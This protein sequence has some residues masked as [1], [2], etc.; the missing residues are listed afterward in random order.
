M[1]PFFTWAVIL[2]MFTAFCLAC[3]AVSLVLEMRYSRRRQERLEA[4]LQPWEGPADR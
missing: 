1:S 2:L 4:S 3:A